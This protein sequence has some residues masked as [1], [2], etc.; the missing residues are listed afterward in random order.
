MKRNHKIICCIIFLC[1]LGSIDALPGSISTDVLQYKLHRLYFPYG[2]EADIYENC[3]FFLINNGDTVY[4]GTIETS[5]PGISISIP[6]NNLF[7]TLDSLSVLI[8]TADID[9]LSPIRIGVLNSMLHDRND[10]HCFLFNY[11]SLTYN[12]NLLRIRTYDSELKMQIDFESGQIDGFFS[13]ETPNINTGNMKSII[14]PAPFVAALIPNTAREINEKGILTTSLFYRFDEEKLPILFNG[15]NPAP[16]YCLCPTGD[17]CLRP[18][19][20]NPDKGRKLL[21]YLRTKP[22]Q[23]KMAVADHSLRGLGEYF[24]D[25]LSRDRIKVQLTNNFD[26]ADIYLQY[27]PY[28]EARTDSAYKYIVNMLSRDTIPGNDI[29]KALVDLANTLELHDRTSSIT[30]RNHFIKLARRTLHEDIGLFPLF[31]PSVYFSA[32]NTLRG[33]GFN[34]H[35]IFNIK[36]LKLIIIPNH[37]GT[38]DR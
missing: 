13:F 17:S 12:G 33:Y 29:N 7:V 25:I 24:A 20:Y 28:I 14:S 22:G 9:G 23:A 38:D 32:R 19:D 6:I 4:N 30:G 36:S 34:R 5:Y 11:D 16:F 10:N 35:G 3:E 2:T 18:Y 15:R 8:K 1:L 21:N 37:S 26:D 31:R 27:I